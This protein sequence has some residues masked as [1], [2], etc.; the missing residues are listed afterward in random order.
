MM[1]V[2]FK[3]M[4]E[5]NMNASNECNNDHQ[6]TERDYSDCLFPIIRLNINRHKVS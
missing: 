4:L 3:S 1:C 6:N 2:E 5:K